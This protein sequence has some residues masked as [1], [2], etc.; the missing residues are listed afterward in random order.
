M[1]ENDTRCECG[2]YKNYYNQLRDVHYIRYD[3]E[4]SITMRLYEN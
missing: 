4:P 1:K 2:S 3:T